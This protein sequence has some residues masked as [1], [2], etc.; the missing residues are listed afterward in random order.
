[1]KFCILSCV[2]LFGRYHFAEAT[3][4]GRV[5]HS[6]EAD[7]RVKGSARPTKGKRN[8][9]TIGLPTPETAIYEMEEGEHRSLRGKKKKRGGKHSMHSMFDIFDGDGSQQPTSSRSMMHHRGSCTS[10]KSMKSK[11]RKGYGC[12]EDCPRPP[13]SCDDGDLCTIDSA[14]C[15]GATGNWR[16]VNAPKV[17][18]L[19]EVCES[20]S[21]DCAIVDVEKCPGLSPSCDDLNPCTSDT[22]LCNE[23]TATWECTNTPVQCSDPNTSCNVADGVCSAYSE[24]DVDADCDNPTQ[25]RCENHQCILNNCDPEVEQCCQNSDC[26]STQRCVSYFCVQ[27]GNPSFSLQW[28]GDGTNETVDKRLMFVSPHSN[29][30]SLCR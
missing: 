23:N 29:L 27:K 15:N 5:L 16:C 24:C 20:T 1:M 10:K 3:D 4:D 12:D 8:P 18:S 17:C 25:F 2:I 11:S 6:P 30:S 21:G 14:I 22:L 13:P 9:L 26:D 28:F 7:P 19:E